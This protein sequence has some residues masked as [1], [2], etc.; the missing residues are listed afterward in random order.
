[1]KRLLADTESKLLKRGDASP[2]RLCGQGFQSFVLT[3]L[4]FHFLACPFPPISPHFPH[5]PPFSLF[6]QFLA[7]P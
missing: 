3:L 7:G 6:P 2:K 1:M 4:S 5:V